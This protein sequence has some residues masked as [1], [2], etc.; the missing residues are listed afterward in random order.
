[1]TC[2]VSENINRAMEYLD[3]L[4]AHIE[5]MRHYVRGLQAFCNGCQKGEDYDR[6]N[7]TD[8]HLRR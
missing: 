6:E 3:A 4:E 1:M 7:K 2:P 8:N 5:L